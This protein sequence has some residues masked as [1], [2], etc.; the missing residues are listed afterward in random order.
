MAF[1]ANITS[2]ANLIDS[3]GGYSDL[4]S[5]TIRQVLSNTELTIAKGADGTYNESDVML[6]MRDVDSSLK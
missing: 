1:D 2:K 5:L 3:D 6:F 4:I